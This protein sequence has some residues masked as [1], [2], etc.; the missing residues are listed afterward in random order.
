M[1][2]LS[3][4]TVRER[5]DGLDGSGGVADNRCWN[6]VFVHHSGVDGR[7]GNVAVGGCV[8]WWHEWYEWHEWKYFHEYGKFNGLSV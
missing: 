7:E 6:V 2:S 1:A 3:T 5:I 8:E 4:S